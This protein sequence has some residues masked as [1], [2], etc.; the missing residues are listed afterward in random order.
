M[1]REWSQE[2]EIWY[3]IPRSIL[4]L[5]S[6]QMTSFGQV[7]LWLE[8]DTKAGQHIFLI[9]MQFSNKTK[10]RILWICWDDHWSRE[11]IQHLA[12]LIRKCSLMRAFW[13][14]SWK[15]NQPGD[16]LQILRMS[17]NSKAST[18]IDAFSNLG[19]FLPFCIVV[20]QTLT[21]LATWTLCTTIHHKTST[22]AEQIEEIKSRHLRISFEI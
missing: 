10:P 14:F 12:Q 15:E 21:L 8:M 5:N 11:Q 9:P 13:S 6:N 2:E 17:E 4:G 16:T 3:L 22:F 1:T 18:S 19:V 7:L 20:H